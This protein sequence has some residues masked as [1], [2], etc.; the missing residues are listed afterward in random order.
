MDGTTA[1]NAPWL[2]P[3]PE[4]IRSGL[5]L[6]P[7]KDQDRAFL[8]TLYAST[9]TDELKASGWPAAAQRQFVHDQ[10][11][12]QD[13]H[14]RK[15]FPDLARHIILKN[16]RAIGRLYVRQ[17]RPNDQDQADIHITDLCLLPNQR[18][19]GLGA[20]LVGLVLD[21]A[22]SHN[23]TASLTVFQDN[24]ALHLYRRQGFRPVRE[25]MGRLAM[26]WHP[27]DSQL[28][29]LRQA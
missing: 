15:N 19:H 2:S 11:R 25:E 20:A 13:A 23:A 7:E 10:F 12:L 21:W 18:G 8:Q 9:R 5:A 17:S 1:T 27:L 4:M 6:R 24:R 14:Y 16:K 29:V 28:A 22:K 26:I 3:T